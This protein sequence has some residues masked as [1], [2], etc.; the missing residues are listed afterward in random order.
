MWHGLLEDTTLDWLEKG[1]RL[2]EL[3]E[4]HAARLTHLREF[5]QFLRAA[6]L[7]TSEGA[8]EPL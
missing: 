7:G 6:V 8:Q 2:R 3:R 4:M 1:Y 5:I